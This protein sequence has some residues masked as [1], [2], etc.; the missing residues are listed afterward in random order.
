MSATLSLRLAL[1]AGG[2]T[3]FAMAASAAPPCVATPTYAAP[4]AGLVNH[5]HVAPPFQWGWFG[6]EH[7]YPRVAWHRDYNGELVRWSVARRY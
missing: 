1:L 2:S 7:H 4:Y 6:A 3:L 5:A